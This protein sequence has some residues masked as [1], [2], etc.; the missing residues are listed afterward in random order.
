M[1][2]DN[3]DNRRDFL[4]GQQAVDQLER[5]LRVTRQ[6]FS[7]P[8]T[9]RRRRDQT[10]HRCPC[11]IDSPVTGLDPGMDADRL[12]IDSLFD[13]RRPGETRHPMGNALALL[14]EI[15]QRLDVLAFNFTAGL[16]IGN[17]NVTILVC[18]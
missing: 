14:H 15:K 5:H 4:L 8:H 10:C 11:L 12:A 2:I 18:G 17:N 9:T 1:T 13:F 6:D 3:I 16:R 7:N